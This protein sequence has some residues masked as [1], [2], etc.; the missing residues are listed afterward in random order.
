MRQL[1]LK[2]REQ[3]IAM[4][5]TPETTIKNF[6]PVGRFNLLAGE[7]AGASRKEVSFKCLT[8]L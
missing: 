6:G 8:V 7:E 3:P 4:E 2:E 5:K 1:E